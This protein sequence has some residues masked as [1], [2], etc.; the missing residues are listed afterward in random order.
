MVG[1][2]GGNNTYTQER[3]KRDIRNYRPIALIN[4]MYEIRDTVITNKL[5]RRVNLPTCETQHGYQAKKSTVG[6]IY[7]IGSILT[8]EGINGRIL[9]YIPKARDRGDSDKT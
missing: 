5:M 7:H 9:L 4:T 2:R 3:D 1:N 6:A 8:R